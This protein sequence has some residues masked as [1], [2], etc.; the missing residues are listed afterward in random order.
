M[1]GIA[2][3]ELAVPRCTF[4]LP[5]LLPIS[6]MLLKPQ[7]SRVRV[8]GGPCAGGHRASVLSLCSVTLY[9]EHRGAIFAPEMGTCCEAGSAP[10]P[11]VPSCRHTADDV[12]VS[13]FQFPSSVGFSWAD[14]LSP[15]LPLRFLSLRCHL[16]GLETEMKL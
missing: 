16:I 6:A 8:A 1:H 12:P 7:A 11:L 2:N 9:W 10:L 14:V 13:S 5:V 15:C 3:K 4:L